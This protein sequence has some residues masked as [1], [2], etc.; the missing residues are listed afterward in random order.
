MLR[1]WLLACVATAYSAPSAQGKWS[2]AL[3]PEDTDVPWSRLPKEAAS[4]DESAEEH[5]DRMAD[6]KAERGRVGADRERELA[7]QR[8]ADRMQDHAAEAKRKQQ[9]RQEHQEQQAQQ[10]QQL[11]QQQAGVATFKCKSRTSMVAAD[12]C[13]TTCL[14]KPTTDNCVASCDCPG[15]PKQ[16][17]PP[18]EAS[19]W[20]N[21]PKLSNWARTPV[22]NNLFDKGVPSNDP[23]VAG[24]IVHCF[25]QTEDWQMS[26]KP[27]TNA[28]LKEQQCARTPWWSTSII[29]AKQHRTFGNSGV[30]L[31]PSRVK[32][33][34]SN[35]MD[36]GSSHRGCNATYEGRPAHPPNK[37][38]EMLE[39]SMGAGGNDY[40]EVLVDVDH[41]VEHL[42]ESVAGFVYGLRG[43]DTYDIVQAVRSY[44]SFLDYFKLNES[45]VPLLRAT[46]DYVDVGE[47][48]GAQLRLRQ[49]TDDEPAFECESKVEMVGSDWCDLTCLADPTTKTCMDTCDCPGSPDPTPTPTAQPQQPVA[50]A[51][52]EN[53]CQ[54]IVMT[55]GA[56][57]CD[58]TCSL[59]PSTPTCVASCDCP[60]APPSSPSPPA[61]PGSSSDSSK[62]QQQAV[63]AASPAPVPGQQAG[64]ATFQCKS[65]V[66]MVGADW[67]DSTCLEDPNTAT[68]R[69]SCDCPESKDAKDDLASRITSKQ[70][71]QPS[72]VD[73]SAGARKYLEDNPYR[74]YREK[75]NEEHPYLAKHPEQHR[76][77][78]AGARNRMRQKGEDPDAELRKAAKAHS[79]TASLTNA[80]D[81]KAAPTSTSASAD[82]DAVAEPSAP[83]AVSPLAGLLKRQ[84]R[85]R[86]IAREVAQK[87]RLRAR[88]L[89]HR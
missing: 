74:K 26:W 46:Y 83:S 68:C 64:V 81:A 75:W 22:L 63:A 77:V 80:D 4:A 23:R 51:P 82:D 70:G 40:N 37:L 88:Q 31:A 33:L 60:P 1:L 2:L 42:P 48:Q 58:H 53:I 73:E 38:K 17:L 67:C 52:L 50:V 28:S 47:Q 30:L 89:D 13:D 29:N 61:W 3:T 15:S 21:R 71:D 87:R 55:V 14:K 18:H 41:F 76:E 78:V 11:Q 49:K 56:D 85:A 20:Q 86:E 7:K 69:E 57:W 10:Q 35:P 32:I 59:D 54:S 25:D 27:C 62:Q 9:E 12:W 24:L 84:M 19:A 5:P 34:C 44:V 72:F 8:R 43:A 36:F 65:K 16:E 6:G 45:Q 39:T 66:S 79:L